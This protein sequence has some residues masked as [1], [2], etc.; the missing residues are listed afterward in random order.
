MSAKKADDFKT[1]ATLQIDMAHTECDVYFRK[2]M[3]MRGSKLKAFKD[4]IQRPPGFPLM[5]LPLEIRHLIYQHAAQSAKNDEVTMIWRRKEVKS[6]SRI[7]ERSLVLR[8]EGPAPAVWIRNGPSDSS[9]WNLAQAC[10]AIYHEA[11]TYVYQGISFRFN[12]VSS[13]KHLPPHRIQPGLISNCC[14]I[15]E[16]VDKWHDLFKAFMEWLHWGEHLDVCQIDISAHSSLAGRIYIAPARH[17]QQALLM[18]PRIRFVA[19]IE[20][21]G[22]YGSE[23]LKGTFNSGRR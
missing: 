23:E 20:I 4:S 16:P 11:L 3:P 1:T 13:F 5:R 8:G 18:W 14:I 6:P 7:D 22:E 21:I 2:A 9:V 10:K 17:L 15:L 12:A 19:R